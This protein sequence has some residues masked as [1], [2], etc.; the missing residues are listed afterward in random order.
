MWG[1][2]NNKKMK[3]VYCISGL[4]ADKRAFQYLKLN[5][6]NLHFIEWIEPL[7]NETISN[8]TS[9]LLEQVKRKN[10][11]LI[12]MSF[13]GMIA[14]EMA[15]QINIEKL[16]LISSIKSKCEMPLLYRLISTTGIQH[17]FPLKK[18]KYAYKIAFWFFGVKQEK[19]KK[20]LKN[21]LI[22]TNPDLF[23]WSIKAAISWQNKN[24]PNNCYHI[25]GSVDKIFP[26][27][28]IKANYVVKDGGHFM[29]VNKASAISTELNKILIEN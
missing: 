2:F 8:Y 3:E 22:D 13:G 4:G 16:I 11:I 7:K 28:N 19:E 26:I 21:I 27:K 5:N 20:F 1:F 6:C 12:G 18:I 9:R 10:P 17:I 23:A 15:K 24:Q 14:V 29:I 25:H